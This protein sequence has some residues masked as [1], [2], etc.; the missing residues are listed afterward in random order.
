MLRSGSQYIVNQELAQ[1]HKDSY[2]GIL[3]NIIDELKGESGIYRIRTIKSTDF[4]EALL[5]FEEDW[6]NLVKEIY[7]YR[8]TGESGNIIKMSEKNFVLGNKLVLMAQET[9]ELKMESL[10]SLRHTLVILSVMVL[11]IYIYSLYTYLSLNKNNKDLSKIAYIDPL[12]RLPNRARCDQVV[13]EYLKMDK[14][15]NLACIFLD[16]NN[17]KEIND[18]LGHDQ[19]DNLLREF[20]YILRDVS[21]EYGLIF[22]NG[23]DEFTGIFEN[24]SKESMEMYI[25]ELNEKIDDFNNNNDLFN[26]SFA[27]GTSYSDDEGINSINELMSLADKRMF[28]NK[29]EYK[30]KRILS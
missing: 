11:V 1:N 2:I 26:I 7:K 5:V 4:Q 30:E 22:R 17:L 9:S 21:S 28:E 13:K 29:R 3:N 16:L 27:Y 15:P 19:G 18:T 8:E 20:G 25:D 6:D 14:L 10:L 12:T 23:G 24:I